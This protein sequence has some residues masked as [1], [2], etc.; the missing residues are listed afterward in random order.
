MSIPVRMLMLLTS[1]IS[2]PIAKVC[3]WG[4]VKVGGGGGWGAVVLNEI[5]SQSLSVWVTQSCGAFTFA[6]EV[7]HMGA[8]W[9]HNRNLI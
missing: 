8:V 3:V 5:S 9:I 1:P 2:F 6:W 7:G 4:G